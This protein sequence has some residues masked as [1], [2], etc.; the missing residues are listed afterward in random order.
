MSGEFSLISH[1]IISQLDNID[2]YRGDGVPLA[3]G[4]ELAKAV[5][6]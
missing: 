5:A 1:R 2:S 3:S 4:R 6:Y